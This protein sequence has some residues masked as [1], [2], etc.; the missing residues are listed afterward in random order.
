MPRRRLL[1]ILEPFSSR[2]DQPP[3]ASPCIDREARLEDDSRCAVL[4]YEAA[5]DADRRYAPAYTNLGLVH[6]EQGRTN[7]A[8]ASLRTAVRLDPSNT[9]ALLNLGVVLYR[10]GK[11]AE[12]ERRWREVI[13]LDAYHRDAHYFLGSLFFAR[14]E[15]DA[16]IDMYEKALARGGDT[17]VYMSLGAA[18]LHRGEYERAVISFEEAIR[19]GDSQPT[20]YSLLAEALTTLGKPA[21]AQQVRDRAQALRALHGSPTAAH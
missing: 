21:E 5:L 18:L 1:R 9:V 13:Q 8:L 6:Y 19:L 11:L 12:A 2:Q 17:K 15:L 3:S 7:Q 20:T 16:A 14:G 10:A 4:N